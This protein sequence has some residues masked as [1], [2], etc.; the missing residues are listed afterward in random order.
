[1]RRP[2]RCIELF[3]AT[4]LAAMRAAGNS[5]DSK[6]GAMLLIELDGEL[7]AC[8]T[9]A[10][11]VVEACTRGQAFDVMV[12]QTAN[13]RQ[14]VWDARRTMSPAIRKLTQYRDQ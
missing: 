14:R 13:Q 3:D 1:M 10:E 8:L 7:D 9:Q 11:R 2:P 5:I 12:A 4:T 6:A